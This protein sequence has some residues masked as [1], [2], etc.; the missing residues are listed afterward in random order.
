MTLPK[1]RPFTKASLLCKSLISSST[2]GVWN[3]SQ[4]RTQYRSKTTSN[5]FTSLFP[6]WAVVSLNYVRTTN[7]VTRKWWFYFAHG[8]A[9][10]VS[11]NHSWGSRWSQNPYT[12]HR[13]QVETSSRSHVFQD[14]SV[15]KPSRVNDSETIILKT[16]IVHEDDVVKF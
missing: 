8:A 5:V 3:V 9:P 11:Y 7:T 2:T 12:P 4:L 15:I 10:P 6:R 16:K 1:C 14:H 13:V